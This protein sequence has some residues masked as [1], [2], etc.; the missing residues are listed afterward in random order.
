MIICEECGS[1]NEE[2][3][4]FCG[5][6]SA[7]LVWAEPTAEQPQPAAEPPDAWE[8]APAS[9]EPPGPAD[10]TP[11]PDPAP[12]EPVTGDAAS[13]P[14][15]AGAAGAPAGAEMA[16]G[17]AAEAAAP[18]VGGGATRVDADEAGPV[19]ADHAEGSS[20]TGDSERPPVPAPTTAAAQPG[21]PEAA[22][23]QPLADAAPEP[24]AGGP[25]APTPAAP[26]PAVPDPARA[27]AAAAMRKP[28]K[29]G[30]Q[31]SSASSPATGPAPATSPAE[32]AA[33]PRKP[34]AR[35]PGEAAPKRPAAAAPAP[36][37]D[38]AA[39]PGDL[40]CGQ[41]GAG[42]DPSRKFCRRCGASLEAAVVV[43]ALPWYKRIFRRAPKAARQA[44]SRPT[45]IHADTRRKVNRTR[46]IVTRILVLAAVV[47][48]IWWLRP[49]LGTGVD[50]AR[51]HLPGEE[52]IS[53]ERQ[54]ASDSAR[55]HGP[56]LTVDKVATTFWSP[57]SGSDAA[58]EFLDYRFEN[59][60]RLV[61]LVMIPGASLEDPAA[62]FAQGRPGKVQVTVRTSD[63][64]RI[65]KTWD[66][67]DEAGQRTLYLGIDDVTRVRVTL[68]QAREG[69]EGGLVA[70]AEVAF[71]TR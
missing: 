3:A 2:G 8:A 54:T 41:C 24:P 60:F 22:A 20:G 56:E 42:N 69:G 48:G 37:D 6:C 34:A 17:A 23:A 33:A 4:R 51:D 16:R 71:T 10:G 53:S 7:Y 70:V 21:Q 61:R 30:T 55:R 46:R 63:D 27:A 31:G 28:V 62:F 12:T 25:P 64:E 45:K 29:P 65:T 66:L 35:K 67:P 40:V 11:P 49:M 38:P 47:A 18:P 43:P 59:P 9:A 44:G 52:Y 1:A 26:K 13:G 58:G 36:A 39:R 5:N 32:P 57:P 15:G 14:V 19:R 50:W 68:L